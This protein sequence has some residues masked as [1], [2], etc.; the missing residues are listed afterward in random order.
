MIVVDSSARKSCQDVWQALAGLYRR[1]QTDRS[2]ADDPRAW[3]ES[4]VTTKPF[5][6]SVDVEVKGE[7][8][9]IMADDWT[10]TPEDSPLTEECDG[11]C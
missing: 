3:G 6:R 10:P 2:Y 4:F 1:C 11:S 8:Q 5:T 7:A 9:K